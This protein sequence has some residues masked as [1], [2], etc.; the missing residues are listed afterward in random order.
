MT[1]KHWHAG[2]LVSVMFSVLVGGAGAEEVVHITAGE[3]PPYLG[4]DLPHFGIAGR[5]ITEAFAT[6]GITVEMTFFPWKRAFEL[7]KAGTFDGT[8]IWLK[9]SAREADFYYSDP[10]I[11][12]LH[13]FFHLRSQPFMWKTL[14]DLQDKTLGG[15]LGF[16]YGAE[17]DQ[18]IASG[19]LTMQRVTSDEQNFKKLLANRIQVYPQEVNVGYTVLNDKFFPG[20][21][22]LI[23]HNDMPFLQQYSYLLL[24]T[25]HERNARLIKAFNTGLDL[26]VGQGKVEEYFDEFRRRR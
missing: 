13:V 15:L 12:E 2:W 7:A 25:R 10:V 17:M 16:S 1:K 20:E 18:A 4:S 11:S 24:T 5:I 21:R 26:L 23:T 14:A 3:W 9:N 8:A 19:L 22:A 6:Q